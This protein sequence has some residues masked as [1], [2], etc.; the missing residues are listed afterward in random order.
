MNKLNFSSPLYFPF[1]TQLPCSNKTKSLM[2]S[3]YL[4]NAHHH[5]IM[6]TFSN[7]S[8]GQPQNSNIFIKEGKD[9]ICLSHLFW[10]EKPVQ[11]CFQFLHG[12]HDSSSS[13]PSQIVLC[14]KRCFNSP[15]IIQIKIISGR[16]VN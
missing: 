13:I 12:Q 11:R 7:F 8:S 2:I 4:L 6:P 14:P 9:N 1:T 5:F 3:R 15:E 16:V 10:G